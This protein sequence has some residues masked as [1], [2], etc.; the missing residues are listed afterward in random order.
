MN[1][2]PEDYKNL[3]DTIL[4]GREW[5][6]KFHNKKKNGEF[7]WEQALIAPIK[8]DLG[9]IANFIAIK[10]DITQRIEDEEKLKKAL[11]DLAAS[12]R[13][14]KKAS[15]IKS[16]FLATMSHEI[17]TPLN[18]IIGM[19]GLLLDT[20]LDPEQ[21]DEAETV[22]MSAEILL[23]L[24]NEILDFSKIEAEKVELENQPFDLRRCIRGFD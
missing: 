23:E 6:G 19:T 21:K 5:R 1:N 8:D 2:T 16:L 12:N 4:S 9:R 18:A 13:D 3:W 22:R 11:D 7:Y 24:I 17:R 14:L 20:K 15:Q 10:E